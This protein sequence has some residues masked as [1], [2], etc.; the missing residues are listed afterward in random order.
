MIVTVTKDGK[1]GKAG[2]VLD[3][4]DDEGR[5]MLRVGV[6][7][8]ANVGEIQSLTPLNKTVAECIADGAA[9]AM[10]SVGDLVGARTDGFTPER[11]VYGEQA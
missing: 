6:A 11:A 5:A 10:P 4:E 7:R 3:L 9:I 8:M 2:T 1:K